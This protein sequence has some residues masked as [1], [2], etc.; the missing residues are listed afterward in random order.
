[1]DTGRIQALVLANA[2][3]HV[4]YERFYAKFSDQERSNIREALYSAGQLAKSP[5]P[6]L[7]AEA[8]ARFRSAPHTTARSILSP[9]PMGC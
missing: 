2:T 1:M 9:A 6:G 4:I 8:C 7:A 5:G 3:G